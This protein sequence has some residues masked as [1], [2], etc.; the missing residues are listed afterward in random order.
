MGSF[1]LSSTWAGY[2]SSEWS[3]PSRYRRFCSAGRICR[4]AGRHR[5]FPVGRD[6]SAYGLGCASLRARS[7]CFQEWAGRMDGLLVFWSCPGSCTA[8][9][10]LNRSDRTTTKYRFRPLGTEA[11]RSRQRAA[12][13]AKISRRSRV[14]KPSESSRFKT[15][16]SLALIA[17][18]ETQG[19]C[20]RRHG[21]IAATAPD[22]DGSLKDS[23]AQS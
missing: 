2:C 1:N 22:S 18:H 16:A 8:V 14:P 23:K 20:R 19:R 9:F 12:E 10:V 3:R 7:R 5:F 21:G 15:I 13:A 11:G 17:P 4:T 6:I